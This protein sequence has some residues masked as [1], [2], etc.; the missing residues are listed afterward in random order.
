[1]ALDTSGFNLAIPQVPVETPALANLPAL[2]MPMQ[3][4]AWQPVKIQQPSSAMAEGIAAG[5]G[6]IG[7]GITAA[8]QNKQEAK[9][10]QEE[11][12]MKQ[13]QMAASQAQ[14]AQTLG[15]AQQRLGMEGARLG[16]EAKKEENLQSWRNRQSSL[17]SKFKT[18]DFGDSG[19]GLNDAQKEYLQNLSTGESDSQAPL[20]GED[21]LSSPSAPEIQL[22]NAPLG[23]LTTP[24]PAFP[25]SPALKAEDIPTMLAS[26]PTFQQ[27]A[28]DERAGFNAPIK[29]PINFADPNAAKGVLNNLGLS[30]I[31]AILNPSDRQTRLNAALSAQPAA[32]PQHPAKHAFRTEE[33]AWKEAQRDIPGWQ[34][35]DVQKVDGVDPTT[36]DRTI[37]YVATRKQVDP[38]LA[39]TEAYRKTVE[40]QREEQLKLR[41][42][43]TLNQERTQFYNIP[44]IKLF[45][46]QNGMQQSFSRFMADYDKVEP[47]SPGAGISQLGLLDMF[48][49][50]E[51]GGR[52]TNTQAEMALQAR[53][54]KEKWETLFN[55]KFG[56]GDVLSRDQMKQMRDVMM[57]DYAKQASYAN[58]AVAGHR[59]VLRDQGVSTL[60]TDYIMPIPKEE[61]EHTVD[62][63]KTEIPKLKL[64]H[65]D[66]VNR[67]DQQTADQIESQLEQY[68]AAA[69]ELRKKIDN[70]KSSIINL[71]EIEK[72]PQGWFGAAAKKKNQ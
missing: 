7:K 61:A 3:G 69:L 67:G 26:Q 56:G 15:M 23:S 10:H 57:E 22:D 52:V 9:K 33:E 65:Q 2:N 4:M 17:P 70:S 19:E 41:Q 39:A 16:L 63:Y 66:A 71:E 5:L 21:P 11:L 64:Q 47:G 27:L 40:G 68:G 50:A 38:R 24:V 20:P 8:Y 32:A 25:V 13:Q 62:W 36:G 18:V 48:A 14:H 45:L 49:R 30:E 46:G 37:G 28:S 12:A 53:S 51:S 35:G 1:M 58:Q 60:P 72:T 29:A 44:Q 31:H 59:D 43:N 55:T 42:Q 6:A 34:P 54:L